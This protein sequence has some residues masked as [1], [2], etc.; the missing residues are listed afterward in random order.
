MWKQNSDCQGTDTDVQLESAT[1]LFQSRRAV[2]QAP[3]TFFVTFLGAVIG[4]KTVEEGVLGGT[5]HQCLLFQEP[6][7]SP[8][9]ISM[10]Q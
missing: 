7:Q 1:W 3:P 2:L 10:G 5:W 9:L 8:C 4:E 6:Q